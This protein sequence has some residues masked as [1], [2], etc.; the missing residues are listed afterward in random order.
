MSILL[1]VLNNLYLHF[2]KYFDIIDIN[3]QSWTAD[4][5]SNRQ[6]NG[7]SVAK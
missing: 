1:N 6:K 3:H 7:F 2:D 4:R 5:R